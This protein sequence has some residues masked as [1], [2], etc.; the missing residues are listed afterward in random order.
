MAKKGLIDSRLAYGI[1]FQGRNSVN[2]LH[3]GTQWRCLH[4]WLADNSK[5]E[6]K[7]QALDILKV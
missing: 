3:V 7:L 6:A 1:L 4:P 5:P 2:R